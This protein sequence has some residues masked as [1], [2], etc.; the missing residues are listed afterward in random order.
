MT[1]P[2]GALSAGTGPR[3]PLQ[4]VPNDAASADGKVDFQQ[5]LQDALQS[6]GSLQHEAQ[7]SVQ[8][9]LAGG[10]ISNVEVM[11]DVRKADL[12]LKLMLQIRNKLLEGFNEIKQMQF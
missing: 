8:T 3:L 6:T 10:D 9:S 5:L 4:V 7:N 1:N 11:T 12:A 2:I